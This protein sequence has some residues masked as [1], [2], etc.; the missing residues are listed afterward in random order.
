MIEHMK[1]RGISDETFNILKYSSHDINS[2]LRG[3]G[4][5]K[6]SVLKSC[7]VVRNHPLIA[8]TIPVHGLVMDPKTGLLDLLSDGNAYVEQSNK[9]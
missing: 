1:E 4:D 7:D 9:A 2:W 8:K 6:T 3:F 5:V